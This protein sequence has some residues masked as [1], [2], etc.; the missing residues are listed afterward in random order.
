MRF[1][2]TKKHKEYWKNRKI[3]WKTS[4]LDTWNHPH[5]QLIANILKLFPWFS[6][7]EVGCGPGPNLVQIVK[8]IPGR[9]VGGV[10]IN[11]DAIALAK[12]TLNGALLKVCSGENLLISDNAT[13]V[14]LTDMMLIYAGPRKIH[15]YI[16]EIKRVA[17]HYVVFCEFHHESWW[18]RL[19][20]RLQEG[21][22]AYNYED[23]LHKHGFY[24]INIIKIPE[25]LWPEPDGT[26]GHEPQKTFGYIIKAK[27]PLRK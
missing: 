23:L 19:K 3:D 14:V 18:K 2:T 13:D 9:Q 22:H 12:E 11:E 1:R 17:R 16:E 7:I 4:Y 6:L 15:K 26:P 25:E 20:L 5:R 10:D 27:L 21:Y 24:D 8:Q